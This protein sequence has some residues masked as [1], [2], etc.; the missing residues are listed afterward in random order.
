MLPPKRPVPMIGA[1]GGEAVLSPATIMGPLGLPV[2]G[3]PQ[4]PFGEK[5][6]LFRRESPQCP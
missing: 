1:A 2:G 4:A 3:P 5:V 6:F